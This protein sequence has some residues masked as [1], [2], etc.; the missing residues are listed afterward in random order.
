MWQYIKCKLGIHRWHRR[1]TY[2]RVGGGRGFYI[3]ETVCM[4]CHT[5]RFIGR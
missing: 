4:H 3:N 5:N 2:H 1:T